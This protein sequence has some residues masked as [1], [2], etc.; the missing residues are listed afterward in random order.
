MM[1][2]YLLLISIIV[3]FLSA[4]QSKQGFSVYAT[5]PIYENPESEF[6]GFLFDYVF[7]KMIYYAF[8]IP[9]KAQQ[10][11]DKAIFASIINE[12]LGKNYVW[13]H[14]HYPIPICII[15][16]DMLTIMTA[17]TIGFSKKF[18]I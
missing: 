18:L 15:N 11:H 14:H 10:K 16:S 1:K 17:N 12:D 8:T 13:K 9:K 6:E 3:I 7:D 5:K 4:C 2:R